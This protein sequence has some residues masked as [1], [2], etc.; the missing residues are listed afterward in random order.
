M[1]V[2]A[3]PEWHKDYITGFEIDLLENVMENR[4]R[5]T[6]ASQTIEFPGDAWV[7][8]L[9][10]RSMPLREY[11]NVRS[12]WLACR[13]KAHRVRMWVTD[14]GI[15][16][17]TMRGTPILAINHLEGFNNVSLTTHAGATLIPG[18]F[19]GV[20]LVNG[21][22]QLLLVRTAINGSSAITIESTPPLRKNANAGAIVTWNKP[23]VDCMIIER[24][25]FSSR[26]NMGEG[27]SVMLIEVPMR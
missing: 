5:L 10:Y 17:G 19:I 21:Y 2:H 22:T 25:T 23:Y 9:E 27:F 12:F 4:S 26:G 3:L 14:H 1:T 16:E 24:P 11:W 13:G 8:G 20:P 7:F 15:P 6:M 18:D